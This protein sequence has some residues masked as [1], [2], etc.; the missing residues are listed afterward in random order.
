M[1]EKEGSREKK[2][3]RGENSYH[4]PSPPRPQLLTEEISVEYY[5]SVRER[6]INDKKERIKGGA[7]GKSGGRLRTE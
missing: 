6:F 5:G 3:K 7:W 2:T 4:R 1:V